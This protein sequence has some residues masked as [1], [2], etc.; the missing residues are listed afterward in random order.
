MIANPLIPAF[1]YDPYTKRLTRELYEH[2]EMRRLRGKAVEEAK[3]TLVVPSR[4]SD[5]VDVWA[6]VLGTLGR[7]GNLRV[8]RVSRSILSCEFFADTIRSRLH[9]ISL[10]HRHH[11]QTALPSSRSSSQNSHPPNSPSLLES[12]HSSKRPAHDSRST[13]DTPSRSRSSPR[14]KQV[15]R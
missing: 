3:A 9:V 12:R 11:H 15:S 7:Q 13:G 1:R 2:D 14:T 10:Q 5:T 4:T 8:L 6:V